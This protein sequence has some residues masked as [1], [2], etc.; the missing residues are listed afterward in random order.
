M[1]KLAFVVVGATLC[2]AATASAQQAPAR[3]IRQL[4]AADAQKFC[5]GMAPAEQRKCLVSNMSNVSQDCGAALANARSVAK[6]FQ[7]AC[8][9]DIQQYCG[10]QP[11]GPQRRQCVMANQAQFSQACQSALTAQRA[12]K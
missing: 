12:P 6:E 11:P 4:C 2:L 8:H 9:G 3:G 7:Q 1:K 5:A 10:S